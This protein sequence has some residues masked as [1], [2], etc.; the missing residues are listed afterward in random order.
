MAMTFA[1]MLS[2]VRSF[3]GGRE[4]VL[5]SMVEGA[6]VVSYGGQIGRKMQARTEERK[7]E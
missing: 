3:M 4:M 1:V 6:L 7:K 5:G 2:V